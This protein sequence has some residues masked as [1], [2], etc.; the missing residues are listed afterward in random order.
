MKVL[1]LLLYMIL[2]VVGRNIDM[3]SIHG[4]TSIESLQHYIN[5]SLTSDVCLAIDSYLAVW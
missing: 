4:C 1:G 3:Y 5:E 2:A